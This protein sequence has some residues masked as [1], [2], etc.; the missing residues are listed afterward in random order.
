[1]AAQSLERR[2]AKLSAVSDR[3]RELLDRKLL[4]ALDDLTET[5]VPERPLYGD[6]GNFHTLGEQGENVLID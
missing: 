1:M 4:S 3:R 2:R 6:A 5:A